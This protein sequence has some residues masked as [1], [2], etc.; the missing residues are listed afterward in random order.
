V[1]SAGAGLFASTGDPNTGNF[2]LPEELPG[3]I[4]AAVSM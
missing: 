2:F 1:T 4:A 3:Y